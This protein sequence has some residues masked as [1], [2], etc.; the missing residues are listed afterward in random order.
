MPRSPRAQA[1]TTT[2]QV[3]VEFAPLGA[4]AAVARVTFE[5]AFPERRRHHPHPRRLRIKG[6]AIPS[7]ERR[8]RRLPSRQRVRQQEQTRER[9]KLWLRTRCRPRRSTSTNRPPSSAL[10]RRNTKRTCACSFRLVRN[11]AESLLWD[12]FGHRSN[13]SSAY[14]SGSI[15]CRINHG[16]IR[17]SLQWTRDPNGT[18]V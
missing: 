7:S 16:S 2:A 6:R 12:L 5:R 8:R 3:Q 4:A 1:A 17:N 10:A 15:P 9:R 14:D 18:F 11:F 13:F